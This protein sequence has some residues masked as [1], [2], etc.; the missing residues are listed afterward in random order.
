MNKFTPCAAAI[1]IA[2]ASFGTATNSNAQSPM[3][4]QD[5]CHSLVTA[6]SQGYARG[7]LPVGNE[8]AVAIAQCQEGNA[9]PA[10]PVLEQKL[11]D[12]DIPL[13]ARS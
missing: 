2:V 9:K 6:Y 4:D 1:A 8:T 11:R 5:Y 12:A 7:S 13:P 10:I 3:S